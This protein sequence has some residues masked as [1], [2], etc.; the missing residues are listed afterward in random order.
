MIKTLTKITY[1]FRYVEEEHQNIGGYLFTS[2]EIKN[3]Q[4]AFD[5]VEKYI[6]EY[7]KNMRLKSIID[8][9]RFKDKFLTAEN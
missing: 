7:D 9:E 2:D 5:L 3:K 1:R 4:E 8:M 6:N